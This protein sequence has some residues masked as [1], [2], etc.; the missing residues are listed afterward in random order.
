[1]DSSDRNAD[2]TGFRRER[3]VWIGLSVVLL[4]CLAI[5]AF[6][7]TVLAQSTESDMEAWFSR[8]RSVLLF[9]KEHY[10]E[11]VDTGTLMEGA[12]SGMF[13]ALDDPYSAYLKEREMEGLSD[14]TTGEFGGVGLIISKRAPES[15]EPE[16][17]RANYV[18]VISPI[19]D[20]PAYRAGI[21]AGDY[22]SAVEGESTAKMT[23]D[24]VKDKLRGEPGTEVTVTIQ[25]GRRLSFNVELERAIV[26]V[27]TAKHDMISGGIGFLRVVRFTPYTDDRVEEAL[28]A[29]R[30]NG[31]DSLI[32]DLR[33]N[34]GGLLSSVIDTADLFLSEG[35]IVSTRS[36]VPSESAVYRARRGTLVR[37][38][39]P[40]VVLIDKGTASAAEIMAGALR[41]QGRAVIVGE[42]SYG[43]GSVQQFRAVGEG[44]FKLTTSRYYT[45]SGT[46]IDGV[47]ITP[48]IEVTDPEPTD[49]EIEALET[50]YEEN[51]I[52]QF[53]REHPDPSSE[54]I[55]EFVEELQ[56]RGLSIDIQT[57]GKLVRDEVNRTREDA[58]IYD[59]D[60]DR[61][62]QRAVEIIRENEYRRYLR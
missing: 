42:T 27:P 1:M 29:F 43:K 58:A 37:E 22:I 3:Y 19:E 2:G 40:I 55:Q 15:D 54:Q 7:P 4:T 32:I 57:V 45:P 39:F 36:R 30:R 52:R 56:S 31:Y 16:E 28:K 21:S 10:V 50:I 5:L 47:G 13:N 11:E 34:P 8:F 18:E 26:E 48:D 38:A 62:L 24:E 44:G 33:S 53:V 6:A 12:L 20:T 35:V 17:A 60:Y 14:V 41:D 46:K 59:L 51:L 9:V 49:E 23:I 61:P 25:R